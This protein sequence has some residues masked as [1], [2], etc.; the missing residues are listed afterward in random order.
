MLLPDWFYRA[1]PFHTSVAGLL[2]LFTARNLLGY[3]AG[4]MLLVIAFIDWKHQIS[5]KEI[6]KPS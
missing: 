2:F 5:R 6:G 1:L 3:A 4:F